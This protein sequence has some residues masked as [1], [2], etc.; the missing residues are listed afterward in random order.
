MG[1]LKQEAQPNILWICTD[2]Q[3]WDTLGCYGNPYVQTPNLDRL[4]EHGVRFTNAYCQNPVCSPSRASFMTGRY[5]HIIG[6]RQNGQMISADEKLVTRL[7]ADRG[8]NCGLSG[9]LHLAPCHTSVCRTTE[10]RIDD[11]YSVFHWS[12]HPMDFDS[13][14]NGWANNEYHVW[15]RQQGIKYET[16]PFRGSIHVE[17]GM[18]EA[19]HHTKWCADR[20]IDFMKANKSHENPWFF[21]V[22]IFDPHHPFDPPA[23]YLE[24]YLDQLDEI[25]LPNYVPGELEEKNIFQQREFVNGAYNVNR[26]FIYSSL[27]EKEHRLIRAAYWAMVDLIDTQT[28]R[29]IE[30]LEESG[31]LE[32]TI[33]IFTSDHGEMLG[34]H[35][36]YMKGPHFYDC[37][38]RVPLLMAW[39]GHFENRTCGAMVE[40]IDLAPTLLEAAGMEPWPG[41]QGRSL[42]PVLT[43][44]TNFHREDVMAEYWNSMDG[45]VNPK[46]FLTMLRDERYKLI[47][48]HGEDQGEL[49]D[50][51]QDPN[52]TWNLWNQ[53]EYEE[54]RYKMMKRLCD[55]IAFSCDPM[56]LRTAPY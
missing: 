5:P 12:H 3:R 45:H 7:F 55:R 25:P 44:E 54:I 28:G 41:M 31:Q 50:L 23:S 40:L 26:D 1:N 29:M 53:P 30:A 21:S 36:I 37:C 39:K 16:K 15:L 43:G 38:V 27:D 33:I 24:R 13:A 9:K 51:C 4:A 56:P 20:A 17:E 22:N 46:P 42:M 8:Y 10:P 34:D 14:E 2:Q 47:C 49:Y 6:C 18:P 19:Y 48:V 11:G 32:N 35:G 52:E